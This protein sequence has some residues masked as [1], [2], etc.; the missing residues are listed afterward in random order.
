MHPKGLP[1]LTQLFTANLK[2]NFTLTASHFAPELLPFV[3]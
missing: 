2:P 1:F 3:R